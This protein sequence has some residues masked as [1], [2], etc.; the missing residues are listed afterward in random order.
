M[1]TKISKKMTSFFISKNAIKSDEADI[2]NYCFEVFLSTILN[3]TIIIIIAIATKTYLESLCFCIAFMCLRKTAG[4]FHA[5]THCRCLLMLLF[6]YGGLLVMI[7]FVGEYYLFYISIIFIVFSIVAIMYLSPVDNVNKSL[8]L[9]EKRT[10][11][12]KSFVYLVLFLAIN[13]VML[14]FYVTYVYAFS[15][16]YALFVVSISMIMGTIKNK[17]QKKGIDESPK[18][19]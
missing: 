9:I 19:D 17:V 14:V 2:Y 10:Q 5:K 16:S 7:K 13:C 6:F 18:V 1:L 11:R 8:T 15:I 3:L 12:R 4:G